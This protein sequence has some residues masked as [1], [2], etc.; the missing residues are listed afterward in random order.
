M[1]IKSKMPLNIVCFHGFTQNSQILTKKLKNL[2]KTNDD[3]NLIFMDGPLI[4]QEN[5]RAYWIYDIENPLNVIW[6]NEYHADTHIHGLEESMKAFIALGTEVGKIDGLLGFSQGGCFV[7][8]ICR[9]HHKKELPFDIKFAIFISAK[10]FCY[11]LELEPIYPL[12]DVLH[13]Y[14]TNDTI[15]P[16]DFSA[17]LSQYYQNKKTYVHEGKHVIPSSSSAKKALKEFLSSV[18]N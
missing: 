18:S 16:A 6:K 14:G 7:D 17:K 11:D 5:A 8:Y 1:S 2:L 15:I 10:Y 12:I 3:I 4:V 9:I 13:M